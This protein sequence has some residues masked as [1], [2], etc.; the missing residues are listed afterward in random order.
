MKKTKNNNGNAV[1]NT[2]YFQPLQT[3]QIDNNEAAVITT[4]V[5]NVIPPITILKCNIEDTRELCETNNISGYALK[6]IS[7][8]LKLF[9]KNQ[10]DYDKVIKIL[11]KKNI[12]YFTYA[13]KHERPYKALLFGLDKMDPK[14]LKAKLIDIGLRCL[15]V[16][17]VIRNCQFNQERI[18]YVVYFKRQTITVNELR[19]QYSNIDYIRVSWDYQRS[20]KNKVTQCYNCQM[21]GHGASRCKVK[22]FCAKCAGN[23][24]TEECKVEIFKCAN[25]NEQHKSNSPQCP[26]RQNYLQIKKHFS[27][28]KHNSPRPIQ[29]RAN[30]NANYPNILRQQTNPAPSIWHQQNVNLNTNTNNNNLFSLEEIQNLTLE[31]INGLKNCKSKA[32]QFQVVTSLACKF[33]Y[34]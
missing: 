5:K 7:I 13:S 11:D 34:E 22:T 12:E 3:L 9:C 29:N 21:F 31:L 6:R 19:K 16:K 23:H 18:I 4:N 20:R 10:D 30:Y 2:N 8:G 25:C 32:D 1:N 14:L 24:K 26:S 33:L 27:N 28:Q 15:D 17:L